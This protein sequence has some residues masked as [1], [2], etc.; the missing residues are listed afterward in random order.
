MLLRCPARPSFKTLAKIILVCSNLLQFYLP[1]VCSANIISLK[2]CGKYLFTH[3]RITYTRTESTITV[4]VGSRFAVV[5]RYRIMAQVS[6]HA[7]YH[8]L[9][10]PYMPQKRPKLPSKGLKTGYLVVTWH[11]QTQP[12]RATVDHSSSALTCRHGKDYEADFWS[13]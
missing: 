8:H 9:C 2:I 12:H 1:G 10:T 5:G 6:P 13:A 4:M 7:F 11:N 3:L